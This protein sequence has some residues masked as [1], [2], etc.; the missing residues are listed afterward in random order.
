MKTAVLAHIWNTIGNDYYSSI[1][2]NVAYE[3]A[4]LCVKD[5]HISMQKEFMGSPRSVVEE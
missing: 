4:S 5:Y 3:L 2:Y 1:E